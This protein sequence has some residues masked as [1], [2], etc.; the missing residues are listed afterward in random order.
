MN[1]IANLEQKR[2][3]VAPKAINRLFKY[4]SRGE[5]GSLTKQI[6]FF[7]HEELFSGLT[8]KDSYT[9]LIA[10]YMTQLETRIF[11]TCLGLT[12]GLTQSWREESYDCCEESPMTLG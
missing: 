10:V 12:Q 7:D 3:E 2:H 9:H 4:I 6:R 8:M 1:T 11:D 5:E